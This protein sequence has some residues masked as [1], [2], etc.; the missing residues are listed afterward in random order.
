M[1]A[2]IGIK[3]A[4]ALVS[5]TAALHLAVKRAGLNL[6]ILYFALFLLLLILFRM[7]AEYKC[8]LTLNVILGI[9]IQEH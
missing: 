6:K 4:A 9:W 5:G 7:R 2:Y 8:L 1:T 3:H